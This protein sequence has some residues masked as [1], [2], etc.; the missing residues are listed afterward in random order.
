MKTV[1]LA[2]VAIVIL[3]ALTSNLAIGQTAPKTRFTE[4]YEL[5]VNETSLDSKTKEKELVAFMGEPSKK[6]DY[7]SGEISYFYEEMGLVF[8]SKDGNVKGLG[9]NFN[10]DGDEKFPEKTFSGTLSLGEVEI[11][12]ETKSKGFSA[13]QT[14][15]FDCPFPLMCFSKDR[16]AKIKCTAAFKETNLTQ[17]VFVIQ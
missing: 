3:I 4:N 16:E 6:V 14:V 5:F 13:N 8:F 15:A 17:V 1:K 9:V 7:P 10:W 12:K 2:L 11:N